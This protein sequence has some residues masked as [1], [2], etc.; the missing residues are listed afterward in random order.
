MSK[1]FRLTVAATLFAL[2][3]SATIPAS[4]VPQETGGENE[5]S[6]LQ[7]YTKSNLTYSTIDEILQEIAANK[8]QQEDHTEEHTEEHTINKRYTQM[9]CFRCYSVT[10]M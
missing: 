5:E 4:P 7:A 2:A 1:S 9:C 6:I 10:M 3:C 8:R